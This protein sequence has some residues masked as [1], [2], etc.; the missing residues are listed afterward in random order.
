MFQ[1]LRKVLLTI[2]FAAIASQASARF[3]QPDW[4]DPTQPGVG[5]DRYAYS[6]NDPINNLDP[7][8]NSW[9]DESWDDVF[10]QDSFNSTFGDSAS[11]WSDRTFGNAVEKGIVVGRYDQEVAGGDFSSTS[12]SGY[13]DFKD[14]ALLDA[15]GTAAS[16]DEFVANVTLAGTGASLAYKAGRW[17][18]AAIQGARALV[19]E[20]VAIS[21][22]GRLGFEL[23]KVTIE[24]GVARVSIDLTKS[25]D[26]SDIRAVGNYLKTKGAASAQVN[27][28]FLANERLN[29]VLQRATGRGPQ[30]FLGGGTVSVNPAK[31][32]GD[33]LI[34]FGF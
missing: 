30:G 27:S 9:L 20:K 2:L 10:G 5:T 8:G 22:S 23:S 16:G 13:P 12:Y 26:P 3:I 1:F 28:G 34:S 19:L 4:L 21:A 15:S 31:D 33:F 11:V 6:G 17:G 29:A 25:I 24:N 14:K 18:Y 7:L 32:L